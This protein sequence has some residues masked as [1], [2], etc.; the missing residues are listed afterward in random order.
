M[1]KNK[2]LWC[3]DIST[4]KTDRIL[5]RG[6]QLELF[7]YSMTVKGGV[8]E[9][10]ICVICYVTDLENKELPDYYSKIFSLFP[11]VKVVMDLD[12]GFNPMYQ[13]MDRGPQ[14]Y[15]AINKAGAFIPVYKSGLY[16][17]YDTIAIL[18]LDC[19]M[20]GKASLEKYPK[21][22]TL[23][24]YNSLQPDTFCKLTSGLQGQDLD[25]KNFIDIWGNPWRGIDASLLLRSIRVPES[26]IEKI[27]PGS[28]NVFISKED[29]TEEV[30]FGFQYF[31]IA[32]KALVAAAGHPFIWQAEM[33]AYP[34]CLAAYGID[35]ETSTDVEISDVPF[36]R[37]EIPEGTLCTYAFE[38]F[39][40]ASGSKW[41]KLKYKE[42][43]PFEDQE[44]IDYG[45]E[46]SNSSAERA[47]YEYCR[48]IYTKHQ[49]DRKI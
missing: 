23:T 37:S 27:K 44:T 7:L 24:Y 22:T 48:E 33:A 31:T 30:V 5:Y 1:K 3:V 42:S 28:Y 10:D 13:T 34:L 26:N 14:D 4:A 35:Y 20:Y 39:S 25:Q 29:F 16:L 47:F 2:I 38:N 40:R 46:H 15:C 41:N 9:E 45:L 8:L 11:K 32:L 18:D 17:V 6:W 36:F 49:I 12:I 21:T 43:T 19:Y